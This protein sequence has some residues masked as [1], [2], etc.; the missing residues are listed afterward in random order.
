VTGRPR[1]HAPP[2]TFP[3]EAKLTDAFSIVNAIKAFHC[4]S[5]TIASCSVLLLKKNVKIVSSKKVEV[6]EINDVYMALHYNFY[7]AVTK[8]T[9]DD[10]FR[11]QFH[12]NTDSGVIKMIV[13]LFL[14][15]IFA[16]CTILEI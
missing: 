16:T 8:V 15:N 6:W 3:I 7:G 12:E 13:T 10:D 4:N 14:G 2:P 9:V 1:Q 11:P 5:L